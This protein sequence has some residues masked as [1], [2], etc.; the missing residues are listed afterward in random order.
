MELTSR[1]ADQG[2]GRLGVEGAHERR[3]QGE[4]NEQLPEGSEDGVLT[5]DISPFKIRVSNR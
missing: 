4:Q 5:H 2:V 1:A 3:E